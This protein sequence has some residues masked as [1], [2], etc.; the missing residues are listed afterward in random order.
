VAKLT[1]REVKDEE[2]PKKAR[3]LLALARQDYKDRQYLL[4]LDRCEAVST[5]YPDL[6]EAAEASRL[7]DEIKGNTEWAK[8]AVDQLGERLCVLYLSL[9]ESWVKKGHPQQAVFY[10]ERVVKLFGSSKHA[11]A[12]KARLAQL[13]GAP[14]GED[15]K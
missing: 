5:D 3:R 10:L 15:E 2:R 14:A 4:C 8:Q 9:A 12:A 11:A 1:T 6:P 13:R 7:A